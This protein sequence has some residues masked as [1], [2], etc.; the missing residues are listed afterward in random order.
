MNKTQWIVVLA[1]AVLFSVLY[2]GF[3]TKP[4]KH[5]EVE[6]QRVLAAVSTDINSMLKDAKKSLSPQESASVLAMETALEAAAPDS[7]KANLYK[8]LS[9]LWYDL[10]KPGISGYFAEK[11]AE[12]EGSEEA[13]SIAGT[14]YS[15]CLQKE[16]E[17]KV[18]SYCTQRAVQA[19]ENAVSI[20]PGNLQHK[21]NL[22]LVYAENPPQDNPMKGVLMLVE[23]N[24]QNPGNP[25][26]LTQLGRLAIK[27]GQFDKAVERLEQAIAVQPD[28]SLANC[29]LVQAYEA[30]GNPEKVKEFQ[31][32]CDQLSGR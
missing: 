10:K 6:K 15:I 13:W 24:K 9:S 23:L 28:N 18:K 17:E 2:F 16:Q 29:L 1:A 21:V 26:I 19:L 22:A 25:L 31:K 11:V 27:T 30:V 4:G 8:R 12:L 20:N 5:K 7:S 32:I 3:D 14:T